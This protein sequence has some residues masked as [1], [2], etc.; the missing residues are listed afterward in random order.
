M[1]FGCILNVIVF[2]LKGQEIAFKI[3]V[4]PLFSLTAFSKKPESEPSLS[5]F[6]HFRNRGFME[7][8]YLSALSR[9]LLKIF[10]EKT[11]LE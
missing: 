9:S 11:P 6:Y 2:I 7:I 3:F 8:N 4:S 1:L 5:D 10:S